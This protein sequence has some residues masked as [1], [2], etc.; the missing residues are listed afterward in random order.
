[1][2][3]FNVTDKTFPYDN[4]PV[5]PLRGKTFN[6][7]WF[8]NHLA[9]P[10]NAGDFFELPA[11]GKATAEIACT[12]D[13]TSYWAVAPDGGRNTVSG[14]DPCPGSP[15]TAYHTTGPN[16]VKGCALAIT[17]KNNV[18]DVKPEDFT[19]FS[20]NQTCVLRRHTDFQVPEQMPACP[21]EGCICA[22]FWIHSQDAGGEENY[23]N[24]FRCKVANAT[25]TV[26]LAKPE[27][28]RRCGPD[29]ENNKQYSIPANC[30]YGAK[31]P[32]YWLN[33][34]SNMFEGDHA[35]PFYNDLYNFADGAQNDIFVDYY[36][37][38]P[39]PGV[40]ATLPVFANLGAAVGQVMGGQMRVMRKALTAQGVNVNQSDTA[41]DGSP[42][43][44]TSSCRRS[45][46]TL[47]R[48]D[49]AAGEAPNEVDPRLFRRYVPRALLRMSHTSRR[50]GG[51]SSR[52]WHMW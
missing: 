24:G 25:S 40:V 41:N 37:S 6:E 42:A 44:P 16:D 3:G 17:Y 7:W 32:L 43:Q 23:M 26:A 48:R 13:A 35:P 20:V 28:P 31:Q 29:P 39:E 52:L 46:A 19:I 38:K 51:D 50:L 5:V 9:Y 14:E 34:N 11:G 8:H 47:S 49:L 27:V 1:M 33:D 36:A 2:W 15:S 21:E 10:P 22:F 18:D 45:P 30:T 4:R 12:K